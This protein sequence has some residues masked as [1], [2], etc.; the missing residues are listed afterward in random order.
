MSQLLTHAA[1]WRTMQVGTREVTDAILRPGAAAEPAVH[2]ALRA[3]PGRWYWQ[4][5]A[6]G[7]LVLI[8]PL[9]DERPRWAWHVVLLGLTILC[10]LGAGAILAG[11]YAPR[12]QPGL[13]GILYS[14]AELLLRVASGEWANLLVGWSFALPLLLI[15]GIHELGHYL[16]ARRYA[17]DVS[18]PWFIPVPP[19]LSLLG[20]LGAFIRLRSPVLDR[21]QLLDVGAA[22]P[23]AGFVVAL[24]V[25]AWG[26]TFSD[27]IPLLVEGAPS[28]V[29]LGDTRILLGE[30]L[31]T[32]W[33]RDRLLPGEGAVHLSLPAFAGWVGMLI[34]ALNLLPLSQ[35]DGGHIAHGLLGRRQ[36]PLALVTVAVLLV[37]AQ[38]SPSW[39]LWVLVGFVAGRGRVSHPPV[40]VADRPI[41]SRRW[42]VGLACLAV[43]ALT[44]VPHP[45]R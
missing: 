3:W 35:L 30:S 45:F 36:G 14:A 6:A 17:L 34:T 29:T 26:Y 2:E 38:T 18:P 39:Y 5:K 28:Y 13:L 44:F 27:R 1:A 8:R 43:F 23:L 16:A 41:P 7:R 19:G 15:L 4:D 25:L 24:A 20:S 33:M 40:L 37:L 11:S 31:L 9:S 42:V 10:T 22:G 12:E 21:R 32:S